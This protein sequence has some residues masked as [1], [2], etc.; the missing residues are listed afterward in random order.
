MRLV[1]NVIEEL[2]ARNFEHRRVA[3]SVHVHP[4]ANDAI[5]YV[6]CNERAPTGE[7][8]VARNLKMADLCVDVHLVANE[9]VEKLDSILLRLLSEIK[10]VGDGALQGC[11]HE[12]RFLP[13]CSTINWSQEPSRTPCII[14]SMD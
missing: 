5:A 14:W 7:F 13:V 11:R 8:I 12:S 6:P 9:D 3:V 4:R 2:N 1:R 10:G